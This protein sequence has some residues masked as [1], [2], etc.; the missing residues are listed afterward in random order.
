MGGRSRSTTTTN[1]VTET[2][3][4]APPAPPAQQV[5]TAGNVSSLPPLSS[6]GSTIIATPIPGLPGTVVKYGAGSTAWNNVPF[7]PFIQPSMPF[8]APS[9]SRNV[10]ANRDAQAAQAARDSVCEDILTDPTIGAQDWTITGNGGATRFR[11]PVRGAPTNVVVVNLSTGAALATTS[12]SVQIRGESFSWLI[13]DT[14][15]SL[16]IDYRV[17][18][19]VGETG[20]LRV[21]RTNNYNRWLGQIREIETRIQRIKESTSGS[22]SSSRFVAGNSAASWSIG[23]PT[24]IGDAEQAVADL[25][26]A[27]ARPGMKMNVGQIAGICDYLNSQLERISNNLSRNEY[28][29][30]RPSTP[31][32]GVYGNAD[33][34]IA[35]RIYDND[36]RYNYFRGG[37]SCASY[38]PPNSRAVPAVCYRKEFDNISGRF[39][40]TR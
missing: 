39:Y 30:I 35:S 37:D 12:Y 6:F 4:R 10:E 3:Y 28:S 22:F 36:I 40:Y 15:L 18:F 24:L 2:V 11:F 29:G 1:T 34:S 21:V 14:A 26:G 13:F 31:P 38:V 7:V 19:N 33:V 17:S 5:I 23:D 20:L 27:I 25:K 8:V 9:F 32:S 16:G